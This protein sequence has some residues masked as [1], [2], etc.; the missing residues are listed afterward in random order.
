MSGSTL[1]EQTPIPGVGLVRP[2]FHQ[3]SRGSFVKP[4]SRQV[5]DA[6]GVPVPLS[7]VYWS[8]SAPGTIR[9]M[10]FQLP[11]TT[12]A[13]IVFA[14]AGRVRDVVLDLRVDSP[15]YGTYAVFDLAA[16]SGAVVVPHGCAHG[17]EVTGNVPASLVYLQEGDFDPAT[18]A[19]VRWD[20]F[21]MDW[22]TQDPVLSVRDAA[23]PTLTDFASPFHWAGQ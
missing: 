17:F 8:Q 5:L 19:G 9:G 18:D 23:L 11:P 7:E 10:H 6:V 1:F 14:T 13:K 2:P 20:S 15:T 22:D 16:D 4:Y 21:G 12:I 3:D